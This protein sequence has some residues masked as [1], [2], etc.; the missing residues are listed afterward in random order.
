MKQL[1]YLWKHV[2]SYKNACMEPL[3]KSYH[4]YAD[5]TTRKNIAIFSAK[6]LITRFMYNLGIRADN[7][8]TEENKLVFELEKGG[9]PELLKEMLRKE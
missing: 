4:D 2:D 1:L 7:V 6:E 8:Y 5:I 3:P 9:I